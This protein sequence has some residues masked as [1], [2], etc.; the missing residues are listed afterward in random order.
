M[1]DGAALIRP[2]G[3]GMPGKRSATGQN[4]LMPAE[5]MHDQGN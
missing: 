4:T 1:P 5:V 3:G 2:T